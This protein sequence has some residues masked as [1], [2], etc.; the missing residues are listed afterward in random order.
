MSVVDFVAAK[1]SKF[2]KAQQSSIGMPQTIQ[3]ESLRIHKFLQGSTRLGIWFGT[4]KPVVPFGRFRAS[5]STRPDHSF[6][7]R[8]SSHSFGHLTY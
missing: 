5:K 7:L 2:N 1:A 8:S 4:R 6:F 3:Q